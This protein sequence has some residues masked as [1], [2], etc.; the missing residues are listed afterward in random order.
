M[1][2]H[3]LSAKNI[4]E[5]TKSFLSKGVKSYISKDFRNEN[6][7]WAMGAS[8]SVLFSLVVGGMHTFDL[9]PYKHIT[10]DLMDD[11]VAPVMSL[12]NNSI[13]S[14]LY[15]QESVDSLLKEV[16]VGGAFNQE[17][18]EF[19]QLQVPDFAYYANQV[20]ETL[21][22]ES[23][24]VPNV[25]NEDFGLDDYQISESS[26]SAI[27]AA[28]D[29]TGVGVGLLLAMASKESNFREAVSS[30][31]GGTARGLF[32]STASTWIGAMFQLGDAYGYEE[33]VSYIVQNTDGSY[34]VPNA[35]RRAS[36]LSMR[37]N[38]YHSAVMSAAL[39]IDNVTRVEAVLERDLD[40]TEKYLT[41]FLG[42]GDSIYFMKRLR[43][44]PN[45]Y[46]SSH[47][48][49]SAPIRYNRNIFFDRNTGSERTFR[50]VFEYLKNDFEPRVAYFTIMYGDI[51]SPE[52]NFAREYIVEN[53]IVDA[54]WRP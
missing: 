9:I 52:H 36:L 29:R 30:Y 24:T 8:L 10:P 32:Q 51:N 11:P 26:L 3:I 47:E 28:S 4:G 38:P 34:R 14:N 20:E 45:T 22:G 48:R 21:K 31:S 33:E 1:D 7:S 50:Q 42:L 54:T 17:E 16:L 37:D 6:P 41:H 53:Q 19:V 40:N 49:L 25:T 27:Y 15:I 39:L 2:K 23:F 44:A 5:K 43:N 12:P 46:P 18:P 35:S 13:L